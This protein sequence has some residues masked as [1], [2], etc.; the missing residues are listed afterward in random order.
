MNNPPTPTNP[1]Q[2]LNT[3][4]LAHGKDL[5]ALIK[6]VNKDWDTLVELSDHQ[7][8]IIKQKYESALAA[9]FTEVQALQVCTQLWA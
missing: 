9:G 1:Q 6:N 2:P 8:R 4:P 3:N 7:A 5:L